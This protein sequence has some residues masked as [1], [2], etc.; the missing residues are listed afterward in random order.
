MLTDLRARWNPGDPV[1]DAMRFPNGDP[2]ELVI[3][4][5]NLGQRG[6]GAQMEKVLSLFVAPESWAAKGGQGTIC[7]VDDVVIVRQTR[8]VQRK[9][10]RFLTEF[11]RSEET[12]FKVE[13]QPQPFGGG[14]G[15]GFF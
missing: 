12:P 10:H 5:Y 14:G 11:K 2:S 15:G 3:E 1:P 9:I 8:A 6:L 4:F 13:A 7:R